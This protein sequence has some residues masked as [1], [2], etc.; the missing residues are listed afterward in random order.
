MRWAD[1]EKQQSGLTE[2]GKEKLGT[3]GVVLVGTIRRD[4]SPRVSPV[5]PHF[6]DGDLCLSMASPSRKVGDVMRDPRIVV[7]SVAIRRDGADGEYKVRGRAILETDTATQARFAQTVRE[8]YGWG[9]DPGTFHLFRI[10][11]DDITF[12]DREHATNPYDP[13]I[14]R[15]P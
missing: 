9:P 6:W 8:L 11:I 10:D 12:I 14:T 15:W 1:V 13:E 2:L 5:T 7:H 3:H 4:G